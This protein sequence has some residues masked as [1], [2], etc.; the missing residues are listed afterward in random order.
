MRLDV[1]HHAVA[2]DVGVQ[3]RRR[4]VQLA[5]GAAC[6]NRP[7]A[8]RHNWMSIIKQ[9]NI[10]SRRRPSSREWCIWFSD[11]P[12]SALVHMVTASMPSCRP[13]S[14]SNRFK[15]RTV[16]RRTRVQVDGLDALLQVR[17]QHVGMA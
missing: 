1:V 15:L 7:D 4:Q 17:H 13:V 12:E 5:D 3:P 10:C 14:V 8:L 16:E 11:Q 6:T 9:V 2:V